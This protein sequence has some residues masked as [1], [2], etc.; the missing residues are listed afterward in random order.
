MNVGTVI[1]QAHLFEHLMQKDHNNM[2]GCG[3]LLFDRSENDVQLRQRESFWQYSKVVILMFLNS[4][5]A[6]HGKL[7][8]KL[9]IEK[10]RFQVISLS[11]SLPLGNVKSLWDKKN[12]PEISNT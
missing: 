3:F 12:F 1:P 2:S 4:L 7:M 5:Y 9:D 11:F 10:P 8:W 6:T